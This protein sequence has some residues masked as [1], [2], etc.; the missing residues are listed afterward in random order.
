[1]H[2]HLHPKDNSGCEEI[3]ALLDACHARGFLH[4]LTGGCNEAKREVN[5]CLRAERLE[6]TRINREKAR[7][8]RKLIQ[9]KWDEI[10]ANS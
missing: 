9:A 7:E 3:M 1:M 5:L 4:K 10:D 2:P 8:K 6:R